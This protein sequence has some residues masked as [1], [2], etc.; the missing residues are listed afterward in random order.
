MF[1]RGQALTPIQLNVPPLK[2]IIGYCP[3]IDASPTKDDV[4]Y[5]IMDLSRRITEKIGQR[6]TILV[7]DQAIYCK[8][9]AISM[10][11]EDE[12]KDM[13][14]RLGGFHI[15][16]RFWRLLVKGRPAQGLKTF[17]L[18]VVSSQK[19][20]CLLLCRG[21]HIP[22]QFEHISSCLRHYIACLMIQ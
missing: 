13:I 5:T 14:L 17:W 19:V 22:E 4:V 16:L 10:H 20:R 6:Y 12:F 9:F 21:K 15:L 1:P 11:K 3:V 18:K 8:A 7:L 2:S